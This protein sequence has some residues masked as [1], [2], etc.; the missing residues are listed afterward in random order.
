MIRKPSMATL[1]L[2]QQ[3]AHTRSF[4]ETARLANMSQPALSRTIR[5]LEED[6]GVRLFD[7]DTRNVT[8]TGIGQ[9]LLPVVERLAADYDDAFAELAQSFAGTRGRVVLGALPTYAAAQLPAELVRF[10]RSHPQVE[11]VL[12]D[13]LSGALYQQ[14]RERQV[15]MA[16]TTPPEPGE[17]DFAFEPMMTDPYVM[18]APAGGMMDCA[19]PARWADFTGQPFIAMAARSSV[20]LCTDRAFLRAG[21]NVKPLYQCSQLA[22]L[23]ALIAAGLGI[24]AVPLSTVPMLDG[25]RLIWR[26]L[27]G[28]SIDRVIGL[29]WV[30]G[31]ALSPAAEAL[32]ARLLAGAHADN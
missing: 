31:R 22:T 25:Q 21:L 26:R 23:G 13:T 1:R 12:H 5:L 8:L 32:K 2:F 27:E 7:R 20:R 14:M 19:G 6:L 30:A 4:S 28:P 10:H 29:A 15:D 18:V 11:V 24:S 3:V 17:S 16:V 9:S